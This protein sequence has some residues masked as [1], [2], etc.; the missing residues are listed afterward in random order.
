MASAWRQRTEPHF[1]LR[2]EMIV[3]LQRLHPLL[4]TNSTLRHAEAPAG[5]VTR[6][7]ELVQRLELMLYR[8]AHS[9]DEYAD[10]ATLER[11]VHALVTLLDAARSPS[12]A[13][14]SRQQPQQPPRRSLKRQRAAS[15]SSASTAT[16]RPRAAA[17]ASTASP[18]ETLHIDL[19]RHVFSFL[20]GTDVLRCRAVSRFFSTHAPLLV[21]SLTFDVARPATAAHLS[22]RV[23]DVLRA[24]P[25]LSSLTI[26]NARSVGKKNGFTRSFHSPFTPS[27]ITTATAA[28]ATTAAPLLTGETLLHELSAAFLTASAT[29]EPLCP[30]LQRLAFL[31]PFDCVTESDAMLTCL[32][33][34]A[35]HRA[36]V[37]P[38]QPLRALV[39]DTTVLG[40]RRMPRLCEL[41]A[42][43]APLFA[44]LE[45]LEIRHNFVGEAGLLAL[46]QALSPPATWRRLQRLGLQGNI[47]TDRDCGRL[48][49]MLQHGGVIALRD[50]DLQDNFCSARG[51][52]ALSTALQQQQRS[53][54]LV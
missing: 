27:T 33:A 34:L 47:L 43:R 22:G 36:I 42:R 3:Q 48:M 17:T 21:H 44:A 41:L 30:W 38:T 15:P 28:T 46:C 49:A 5:H 7:P 6:I 8:T 23:A 54:P 9:I 12:A 18:L 26:T 10:V 40:D 25:R 29:A 53:S 24:C 2:K 35:S 51:L 11:R 14:A 45:T 1:A 20:V 52:H 19:L 37:A 32:D 13:M 50:V 31:S 39:L 4:G 16:K